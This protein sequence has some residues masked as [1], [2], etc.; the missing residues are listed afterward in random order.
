MGAIQVP[1]SGQPL[2]MMSERP[3][4]GG[5]PKIAVIATADLPLLA[6]SPPGIGVVRF[7]LTE[8]EAAQARWRALL[9]GLARGV[10]E[11]DDVLTPI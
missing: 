2:V 3:T 8:P 4:T 7:R 5:Y 9:D 11:M 6:Q 1:A 10:T